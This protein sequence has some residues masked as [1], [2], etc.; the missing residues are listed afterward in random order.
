MELLHRDHHHHRHPRHHPPNHCNNV[1]SSKGGDG[2]GLRA[3]G[4]VELLHRGEPGEKLLALP[5]H[6]R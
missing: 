1:Y 2:A 6:L 4:A 3:G 5:Q